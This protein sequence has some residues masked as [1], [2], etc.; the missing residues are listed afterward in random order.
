MME[1]ISTSGQSRKD[2]EFCR[3]YFISNDQS[4]IGRTF[5]DKIFDLVKSVIIE[6]IPVINRSKIDE[7]RTSLV[8]SSDYNLLT[9]FRRIKI[10]LDICS[11]ALCKELNFKYYDIVDDYIIETR[12][13]CPNRKFSLILFFE[14]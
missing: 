3:E 10:K 6:S 2:C 9:E 1:E 14:K 11:I 4:V 13:E 7:S 5:L 8:I 12:L